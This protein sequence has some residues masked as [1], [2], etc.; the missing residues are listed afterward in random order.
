MHGARSDHS[1]RA[2]S[3]ATRLALALCALA[4]ALLSGA[5]AAAPSPDPAR[6]RAD[7]PPYPVLLASDKDRSERALNAWA[8][9]ARDAGVAANPPAP[10]LE[11]ATATLRALPAAPPAVTLRL[12]LVEIKDGDKESADEATRE[13]LR[14]FI[15]G[16]RDLLGVTTED[17]SLVEVRDDAGARVARYQQKPFPFPL[18][19][20][21][22]RVEIRFAPD[23]TVLALSSTALPD[24]E[25]LSRALAAAR[26]RAISADDVVKRLAGR[27]FN[28]TA[29][30]GASQTYTV[31]AGERVEARELVVYPV[32]RAGDPDTLELR[33]AWETAVGLGGGVL[34]YV[35]AVTGDV[36]AAAQSSQAAR[37]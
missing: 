15:A 18:R 7:E 20:G 34:A 23:R 37:Q 19:G 11:P 4:L 8:A 14:R 25:R 22:G 31:A 30:S 1:L 16:A 5:C 29:G 3:R 35:D 27:A 6:P 33:L 9:L 28:V 24:T 10:E 26:A 36:L 12:P 32:T 21:Y 2:R 17:L 13:S